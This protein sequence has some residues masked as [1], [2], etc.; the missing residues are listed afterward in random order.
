MGLDS[1]KIGA[2]VSL[3]VAVMALV[4]VG[5]G[6]VGLSSLD[7]YQ[8]KARA[9]ENAAQRALAAERANALVYAVVMD[10]RGVY[11]AK[12]A[13]DA[14][15]FGKPLLDFLAR[16]NGVS[17]EWAGLLN[18]D[19]RLAYENKIGAAITEFIRFRTELVR[20]SQES[21]VA[22]ARAYGDNEANRSNRK[23]LNDLLV[24]ERRAVNDE[25]KNTTQDLEAFYADR[26][27]LVIWLAV[28]GLVVG[29]GLAVW[30]ARATIVGPIQAIT[31]VM[32]RL[33]HSDLTVTV[34]GAQ[35]VDEI[36]DMAR[37]VEV[38]RDNMRR[39]VELE[40]EKAAQ[41]REREERQRQILAEIRSFDQAVTESLS[42]L[43]AAAEGLQG[44]SETLSATAEETARQ[45]SA[46]AGASDSTSSNVQTVAAATEELTSSIA[47]IARQVAG[48]AQVASDAADEATDT[49]VRMASLV[50]AAQRIGDIVGLINSIA[51]Q[52]NLLA[53]NATIEA[54]RAG[55]AG[56][57]FA[58]VAQEVKTLA[59][60]TTKATDD[61]A[62]QVSSIQTAT[63]GAADA[64]GRIVATVGR[65]R[66]ISSSI[67]GAVEEQR[68]AT[69]EIARNVQHAAMGAAEVSSN[70]G[71]VTQSA[72]T[73]G[74]AASQVLEASNRLA[75]QG[76]DL[77][78][79]VGDFL[80]KMRAA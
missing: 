58:V 55:E 40:A 16:L 73:T 42:A 77:R 50:E 46:V 20:L 29:C 32:G 51:S 8:E 75:R 48:A 38:F 14:M 17:K 78:R 30:V 34:F 5:L 57:G 4:I 12:D 64:I 35:R 27:A 10:S 52:T 56:K 74:A 80:K 62:A 45:A 37:A 28:A 13:A 23:A 15:R 54:A 72:A 7:R 47:E 22:E 2:R 44:T 11:M 60:Q 3:V 71:G 33:A 31:D 69:Q 21:S 43:A 70:V 26:R 39:T 9:M 19:D 36:G 24:T 67:A 61:I 66:E 53:L 63:Q 65:I 59:N 41:N 68:A 1:L 79:S 76:D 18:S 49:N 25:L 6:F